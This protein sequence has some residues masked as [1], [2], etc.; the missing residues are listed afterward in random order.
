MHLHRRTMQRDFAT[1]AEREARRRGNGRK[2]GKTQSVIG[3]LPL[4]DQILDRRIHSDI[5]GEQSQAQIGASREIVGFVMNDEAF[6]F[7]LCRRQ[8]RRP[9][10]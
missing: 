3:F 1:A 4:L 8:L 10:S 6:V 2:R 9:F 7:A 5:E